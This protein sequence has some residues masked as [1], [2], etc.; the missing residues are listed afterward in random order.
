MNLVYAIQYCYTHSLPIKLKIP[1]NTFNYV[2]AIGTIGFMSA[3][4]Y[5]QRVS[6]LF[7]YQNYLYMI[8]AQGWGSPASLT[9]YLSNVWHN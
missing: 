9:F 4:N 3:E 5:P 2:F 7:S 8:H 1:C 6:V